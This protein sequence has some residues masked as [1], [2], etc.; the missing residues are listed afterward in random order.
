MTILRLVAAVILLA[1]PAAALQDAP[2]GTTVVISTIP[3]PGGSQP[4]PPVGRSRYGNNARFVGWTA[5]PATM[6]AGQEA[7][8][9]VTFKNTGRTEWVASGGFKLGS[10]NPQDNLLWRDGRVVLN[11]GERVKPNKMKIFTFPIKAPMTAGKYNFRWRMLREHQEWFGQ[12]TPNFEVTVEGG[13]PPTTP[14]GT[15]A[16]RRG[17][18][19]MGNW[20]LVDDDGPFNAIGY[21]NMSA[22]NQ[23][24]SRREQME[25]DLTAAAAAGYHFA[26]ILAEVNSPRGEYWDGYGADPAWPDYDEVLTGYV[27][28]A[29]SKG[30]RTELTIFG[31]SDWSMQDRNARQNRKDFTRRV[32]ALMKD[33]QEALVYVEIVN[34]PG[35]ARK[36]DDIEEMAE[37]ARI[38]KEGLP[39][40]PV[41]MGAPMAPGLEQRYADKGFP[42]TLHLDRDTGKADGMWRPVRQPWEASDYGKPWSN[43]E[44]IGPGSSVSTDS[45]CERLKATVAATFIAKGF[46]YVFHSAAG[47]RGIPNRGFESGL[48]SEMPCFAEMPLMAAALPAGLPEFSKK[49][50]HWADSP[51]KNLDDFINGNEN[52]RGLM[53]MYSGMGPDGKFATV[54]LHNPQGVRLQCQLTGPVAIYK[55]HPLVLEKTEDCASGKV[56]ELGPG[57]KLLTRPPTAPN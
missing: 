35:I 47:V 31:G 12:Y 28:H 25:K 43:N 16:K 15:T 29:W 13:A 38:V 17:K 52:R 30:I 34:E 54:L 53:R 19:R 42:I 56:L 5:P 20:G 6:R 10:Q 24:R 45:D 55:V 4:R 7:T 23:Y 14:P 40:T 36:F 18:P 22:L 51:F 32:T 27:R 1:A 9:S 44:P 11:P 21:T 50:G 3:P 26:R 57:A 46:A 49:N 39:G 41:A 8:V 48:V 33:L 37:L 2:D